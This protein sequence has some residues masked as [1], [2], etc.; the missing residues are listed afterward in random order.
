[1]ASH[2]RD[3]TPAFGLLR[4]G[5]KPRPTPHVFRRL[6]RTNTR[7][8]RGTV[9]KA[10]KKVFEVAADAESNGN[11]SEPALEKALRVLAAYEGSL[12]NASFAD[13]SEKLTVELLKA[14]AS[15]WGVLLP[16]KLKKKQAVVDYMHKAR[17]KPAKKPLGDVSN[18]AAVI[19]VAF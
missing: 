14:L 3:L 10:K 19:T 2:P 16:K 9:A 8:T 13:G 1:M 17:S 12:Q 7:A 4:L 6:A 5:P 11:A 15:H 18:A